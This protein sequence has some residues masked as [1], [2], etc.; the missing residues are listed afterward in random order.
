M[1][2]TVICRSHNTE[3]RV[4]SQASQSEICGGQSRSETDFSSSVLAVSTLQSVLYTYLL[5]E[6]RQYLI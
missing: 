4:K 6:H 2:Q 3:H 5:V 1:A